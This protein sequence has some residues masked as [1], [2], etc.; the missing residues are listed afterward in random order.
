MGVVHECCHQKLRSF[1]SFAKEEKKKEEGANGPAH[2]LTTTTNTHA[3]REDEEELEIEAVAVLPW[4]FFF[5]P[6]QA[7]DRA[8]MMMRCFFVQRATYAPP[9][10][11]PLTTALP[12]RPPCPQPD[13]H[14][15]GTPL[16][17]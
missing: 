3:H 9:L 14:R 6:L 17:V 13:L 7:E 12:G 15:R 2:K 8:M 16:I 11:P 5:L 4:L 1:P 10:V